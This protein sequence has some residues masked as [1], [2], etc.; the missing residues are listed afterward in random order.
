ML[1]DELRAARIDG[2][3]ERPTKHTWGILRQSRI[4]GGGAAGVQASRTSEGAAEC[5]TAGQAAVLGP[6][7]PGGR[8]PVVSWVL[9]A[10]RCSRVLAVT[11]STHPDATVAS[12]GKGF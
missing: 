2:T 4:V 12:A 7:D 1:A 10:C 5:L 11:P 6:L 9:S 8:T 3:N